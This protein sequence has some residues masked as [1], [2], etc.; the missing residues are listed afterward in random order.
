MATKVAQ[1]AIPRLHEPLLIGSMRNFQKDR[2][3]LY[4]QVARECGD[5][6]EVHFGPVPLLIFNTPEMAHAILVEHAQDFDKGLVLHRAFTPIIGQGLINNEGESWRQQRKLM[7]PAFAHRQIAGY[8]DTI[9]AYGERVQARWAEGAPL[10]IDQEMMSLTMSIIGKVLF[11]ADVLEETD[12]LGAAV[13]TAMRQLE[14]TI[15]H[16]FPLPLGIP[17][18]RNRQ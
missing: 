7:A 18:P 3:G 17:T 8:A 4:R 1:P 14:Y 16:M 2:L 6:G 11:D 9:V 10:R 12:E 13:T 15:S 5:A